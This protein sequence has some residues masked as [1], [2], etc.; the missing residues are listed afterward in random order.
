MSLG[1]ALT[2]LSSLSVKHLSFSFEKKVVVIQL[3]SLQL[4]SFTATFTHTSPTH[5]LQLHRYAIY[6]TCERFCFHHDQNRKLHALPPPSAIKNDVIMR[7]CTNIIQEFTQMLR[8]FS[9]PS[10][11]HVL[12]N[13]CMKLSP[14]DFLTI[15]AAPYLMAACSNLILSNKAIVPSI[16]LGEAKT[17]ISPGKHL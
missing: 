1:Y 11:N 15:L 13:S 14:L 16:C 12:I 4:D 9:T 8:C 2:T 17:H 3:I 6:S 7:S 5:K 10:A